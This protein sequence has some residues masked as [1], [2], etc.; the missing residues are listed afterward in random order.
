MGDDTLVGVFSKFLPLFA[1]VK[2]I[3]EVIKRKNSRLWRTFISFL[4]IY[5]HIMP[6][7]HIKVHISRW[8]YAPNEGE[9]FEQV[10]FKN[11]LEDRPPC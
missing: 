3:F 5:R 2:N 4:G 1:T 6:K 9:H 10:F 8:D 11:V 7:T